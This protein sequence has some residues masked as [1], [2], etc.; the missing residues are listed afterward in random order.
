[1]ETY[2]RQIDG[3]W[4]AFGGDWDKYQV[5]SIGADCPP[6]ENNGACWCAKWTDS[7][8]K[9]VA[10]KSPTRAAAYQKARRHGV[11]CGEG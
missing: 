8:I 1:M 3:N 7:G 2:I 11:Y 9:Y 10:S 6:S 5:Y 4:Y